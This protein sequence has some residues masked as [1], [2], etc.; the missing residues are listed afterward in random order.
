MIKISEKKEDDINN[1]Y[2]I[3]LFKVKCY[4]TKQKPKTK[5]GKSIKL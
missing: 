1:K 2:V 4:N 5:D 3:Q